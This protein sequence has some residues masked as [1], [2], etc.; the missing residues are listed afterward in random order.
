[1]SI[2]MT[3]TAGGE[4][5]SQAARPSSR[6]YWGTAL[7]RL[8]ELWHVDAV[9]G[10]LVEH[11]ATEICFDILRRLKSQQDGR[12]CRGIAVGCAPEED[13]YALPTLAAAVVLGEC[14][15]SAINLGPKTPLAVLRGAA[16]KLDLV[17]AVMLGG[18][19]SCLIALPFALPFNASQRD[20]LLLAFLG[21][22]QLGLPA[23]PVKRSRPMRLRETHA[24]F[25]FARP[26]LIFRITP[27]YGGW[28]TSFS[29][30][31]QSSSS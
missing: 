22:T 13:V 9:D 21:I 11:R 12:A 31:S 5:S 19:L 20:L 30:D 17:P 26:Q 14:G 18:A 29:T 25:S 6:G 2:A 24:A 3:P 1:M 10:I 4:P 27:C 28:A 16:A 15:Y 7:A 8:G 23:P